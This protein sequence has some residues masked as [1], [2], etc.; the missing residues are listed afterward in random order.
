MPLTVRPAVAADA[1]AWIAMREALYGR[2][3]SEPADQHALE[4]ARY[5]AGER[6]MPAEVLVAEA[7]R[8]AAS[9]GSASPGAA[10]LVG[11]AELSIRP[12]AEGCHS[13]RVAYL[14][15]WW[16][17]PEARG[18]RVGRALVEAAERWAVAQGCTEMASDA[19]IDND[20]SIA[21]HRALGFDEVE[22]IVCFRKP[23]GPAR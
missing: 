21:A 19:L 23:V 4:V 10:A 9:E 2:D 8:R 16:V 15:G 20:R 5:F 11:F 7:A 17:D 22:R 6:T 18:R 3:A 13:G 14:E 1:P 12:Y